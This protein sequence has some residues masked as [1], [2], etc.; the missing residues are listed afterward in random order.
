MSELDRV[1]HL[2]GLTMESA[3]GLLQEFKGIGD[4]MPQPDPSAGAGFRPGKGFMSSEEYA[5]EMIK[6]MEG[7]PTDPDEIERMVDKLTDPSLGAGFVP[8]KGF[9]KADPNADPSL[10]AGFVPGKGFAKGPDKPD[11]YMKRAMRSEA[12][13]DSAECFYDLQ[14]EYCGEQCPS[15]PHKVLIDELVRYLSGD[16]LQDFCDDFRRHNMDGMEESKD[17]N[18]LKKLA[19][20]GSYD[21]GAGHQ[22]PGGYVDREM[23]QLQGDNQTPIDWDKIKPKDDGRFPGFE[24]EMDINLDD[25]KDIKYPK[26]K[27]PM[28]GTDDID[29]PRPDLDDIRIGRG[30]FDKDEIE[31]RIDRIKGKDDIRRYQ[32]GKLK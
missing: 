15:M 31:R 20:L 12:V 32:F 28:P 17:L 16:Q 26:P 24:P 4:K 22:G 5:R 6:G 30:I 3:R 9:A 10:G 23:R 19:G 13:G 1:K 25:I 2:A 27:F 21:R 8:G 11:L 14:D 18:E 29:I 7:G